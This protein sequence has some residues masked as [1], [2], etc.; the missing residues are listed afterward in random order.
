MR[1]LSL[2]LRISVS[3]KRRLVADLEA[4]VEQGD[5][6]WP[7]EHM[8]EIV[9]HDSELLGELEKLLARAKVDKDGYMTDMEEME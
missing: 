5:P 9:A 8:R 7:L 6:V 4:L 3:K 1:D 2:S